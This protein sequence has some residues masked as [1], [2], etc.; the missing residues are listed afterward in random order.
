MIPSVILIPQV[1]LSIVNTSTLQC[2]INVLDDERLAGW[3][4]VEGLVNF[5][6]LGIS[7]D[8]LMTLLVRVE[9]YA[10][11]TDVAAPSSGEVFFDNICVE[12]LF[13]T[14][15]G[16]YVFICMYHNTMNNYAAKTNIRIPCKN[17]VG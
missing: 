9:L 14:V 15:V 12:P 8:D 1:C 2:A 5:T 11:R 7:R 10:D 13:A 4:W 3:Q 17:F 6:T 16:K